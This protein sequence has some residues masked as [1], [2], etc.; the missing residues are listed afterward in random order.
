[1]WILGYEGIKYEQYER[2]KR[3][4]A[5]RTCPSWMW[6]EVGTGCT[7]QCK[8]GSLCPCPR[9]FPEDRNSTNLWYRQHSSQRP[10]KIGA[11]GK[12]EQFVFEMFWHTGIIYLHRQLDHHANDA[13]SAGS[14]VKA[15]WHT[16][17]M[18]KSTISYQTKPAARS[19]KQASRTK[20][21]NSLKKILMTVTR[22][23]GTII[24][25]SSI[26]KLWIFEGGLSELN[27]IIVEI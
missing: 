26:S 27:S 2:R 25:H 6:S 16:D 12:R 19:S 3:I 9:T 20:T 17:P 1:M 11:N 18:Q 13:L 10:A 14:E 8:S 5:S 21:L 15:F 7:E 23:M 4:S 22:L 24:F